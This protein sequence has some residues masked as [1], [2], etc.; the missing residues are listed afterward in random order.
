MKTYLN[1]E[2][3]ARNPAFSQ[4][5]VVEAPAKTIYVGG[6]NAVTADGTIVGDTLAE[7]TRQT[8]RN[9]E[10]ALAAAGATV[11]DVVRWTVAIVDGQPLRE[12][13]AAFGAVR[14]AAADPPAI[15]VHVVSGLA[16]PRFLVEIDAIA[17]V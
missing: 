4:V 9:V 5:V 13:F 2:S 15:S 3:L 1:P 16:N 17:V 12:G 7:Q 14:G 11:A 6:Q 8:L 10:A